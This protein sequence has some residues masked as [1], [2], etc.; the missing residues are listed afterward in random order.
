MVRTAAKK[1][2]EKERKKKQK[3]NKGSA[4]EKDWLL[5]T[6]G[7]FRLYHMNVF[8]CF[9]RFVS[10]Q[11]DSNGGVKKTRKAWVQRKNQ[12]LSRFSLRRYSGAVYY[13]AP[14]YTD[15]KPATG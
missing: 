12:N 13:F 10:K 1:E 8:A 15:W 2:E 14:F 7:N 3:M 4:R 6:K 5:T 9:K 11:R